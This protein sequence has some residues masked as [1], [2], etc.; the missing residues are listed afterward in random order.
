MGVT[1]YERNVTIAPALKRAA[2]VADSNVAQAIVEKG[3]SKPKQ[4]DG[5]EL[6]RQLRKRRAPVFP[7]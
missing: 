6:T 1:T 2:R 4:N 3:D 7:V 5:R